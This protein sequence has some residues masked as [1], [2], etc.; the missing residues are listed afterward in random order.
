MELDPYWLNTLG[1]KGY[2]CPL[3]WKRHSQLVFI[4]GALHYFFLV[5]DFLV[6]QYW[7]TEP[8]SMFLTPHK[9]RRSPVLCF[10]TQCYLVV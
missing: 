5:C 10:E 3:L 8:P 1:L 6:G 4:S 9:K 7:L 2:A